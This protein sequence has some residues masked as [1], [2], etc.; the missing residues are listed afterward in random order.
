MIMWKSRDH[1]PQVDVT[2]GLSG[3]LVPAN[4]SFVATALCNTS[5]HCLFSGDYTVRA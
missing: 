3:A 5:H 1:R 2:T 4:D